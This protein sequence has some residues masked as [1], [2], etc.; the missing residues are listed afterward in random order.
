MNLDEINKTIEAYQKRKE[1]LLKE[2]AIMDYQLAQCIANSVAC[3]MDK[4]NKMPGVFEMY[5]GLF[6]KE[7]KH[8]EYLK[9]QRELQIQKQRMLDFANYHNRKWKGGE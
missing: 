3:S 7:Y 8:D 1:T 5:K 2:R 9:K 4:N 6:E